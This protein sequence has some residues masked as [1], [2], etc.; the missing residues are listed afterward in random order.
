MRTIYKYSLNYISNL[1]LSK[2][3]KFLHFDMQRGQ[4]TVWFE[5]NEDLEEENRS[6]SIFGTGQGIPDSMRYLS[7][8]LDGN[9]VW[10]LYE[11][12]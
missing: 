11:S 4:T 10:H 12:I 9:F 7:T 5:I 6:F 2:G 8:C 1:T 3:A